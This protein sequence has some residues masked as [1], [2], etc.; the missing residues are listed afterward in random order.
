MRID[1]RKATPEEAEKFT[2]HMQEY[3]SGNDYGI[4]GE[5]RVNTDKAREIFVKTRDIFKV[6]NPEVRPQI[7]KDIQLILNRRLVNEDGSSGDVSLFINDKEYRPSVRFIHSHPKQRYIC[8]R[9]TIG[10]R[11]LGTRQRTTCLRLT[12]ES[13]ERIQ[14][15][16]ERKW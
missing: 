8:L 14:Q 15:L 16:R 2:T 6:K 9:A 4:M 1:V 11:R 10:T 3:H 7:I 5:F 12:S 13:L